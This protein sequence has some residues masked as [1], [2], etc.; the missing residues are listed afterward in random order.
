[1][2]R[3]CPRKNFRRERKTEKTGVRQI[4]L[5]T[6]TASPAPPTAQSSPGAR[7]TLF[8]CLGHGEDLPPVEPAAAQEDRGVSAGASS[9]GSKQK[10]S[11]ST[12]TESIQKFVERCLPNQAQIPSKQG[13][14]ARNQTRR[15][16]SVLSMPTTSMSTTAATGLAV[17]ALVRLCA[18]AV[19]PF[20]FRPA[21]AS[22]GLLWRAGLLV[23]LP[24]LASIP[25]PARQLHA[26]VLLSAIG[27]S[28][29]V[30]SERR[31]DGL[32]LEFAF[33]TEIVN[34]MA[35]FPGSDASDGCSSDSVPAPP[36]TLAVAVRLLADCPPDLPHKRLPIRR[37]L[38][39]VPH[40]RH[41]RLPLLPH[42]SRTSPPPPG[43]WGPHESLRHWH[44]L[45]PIR[46]RQIPK[47]AD[48]LARGVE[49]YGA[50]HVGWWRVVLHRPQQLRCASPSCPS[51]AQRG[52]R[53]MGRCLRASPSC[54]SPAQRGERIMG[55]C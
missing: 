37:Y 31:L 18:V 9:F 42:S 46:P 53:I 14:E 49:H 27:L 19:T 43:A 2:P 3:W 51:P 4:R 12:V 21:S 29:G 10:N 33:S 50:F 13:I 16:P 6:A 7:A 20:A 24:V 26:A 36:N 17:G 32:K 5:G 54:P 22:F 8:G 38:P 52:E 40:H 28:A 47:R 25:V 55:R 48:H 45:R 30:H 44:T 39:P 35:G 23:L 41:F 34:N 11:N 1:M 15:A